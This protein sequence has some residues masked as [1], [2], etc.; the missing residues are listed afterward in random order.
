MY[1]GYMKSETW[2]SLLIDGCN[3]SWEFPKSKQNLLLAN[4][5]NS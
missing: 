4:E 1:F 5:P 2:R 3:K